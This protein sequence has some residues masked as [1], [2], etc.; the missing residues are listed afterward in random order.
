MTVQIRAGSVSVIKV[1][2][3][4]CE[5]KGRFASFQVS[6]VTFADQRVCYLSF[7]QVVGL[8]INKQCKPINDYTS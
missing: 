7:H 5:I 3:G 8:R 1:C 6:K 2:F 4:Y